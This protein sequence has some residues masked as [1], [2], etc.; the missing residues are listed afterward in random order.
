MR[1]EIKLTD[2]LIAYKTEISGR[3]R[4]YAVIGDPVSHSLSPRIMNSAFVQT[5]VDAVYIA[6]SVRE[7]DAGQ[8]MQMIRLFG[9]AGVNVTMPLKQAIVPYLDHLSP[10]AAQVGTANC[11]INRE[12]ILTGHNTD[13]IGFRLSLSAHFKSSP[14]RAFLLGAGGAA[15]AIAS[16]L[17]RWGCEKLLIANR[18]RDKAENLAKILRAEGKCKISVLPWNP[19]DWSRDLSETDLI[20]NA[21][22]LG[23]GGKGSV[24]EL[25]RWDQICRQAFIFE[26]VYNPLDTD[27][28]QQARKHRFRTIGGTELLLWQAVAGFEIWTG[29]EAPVEIM[30]E[31]MLRGLKQPS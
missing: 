24:A 27:L 30:R 2:E 6:L 26:T 19:T 18:S 28:L 23:M 21:T 8:A 9:L 5:G 11:V 25:L 13:C 4:L 20:I 7:A 3:T 16:E 29:L 15:R 1:G 14:A 12:G 22:S 10:A 17:V 31:S